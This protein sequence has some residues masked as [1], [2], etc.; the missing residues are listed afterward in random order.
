MVNGSKGCDPLILPTVKCK[1]MG[2]AGV[3]VESQGTRT[4]LLLAK[5]FGIDRE[6]PGFLRKRPHAL[7]QNPGD[8]HEKSTLSRI[9]KETEFTHFGKNI[10]CVNRY[11]ILV[12]SYDIVNPQLLLKQR[13][14]HGGQ[15]SFAT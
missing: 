12:C 10:K 7:L 13:T 6:N 11:P 4:T 3:R 8:A 5:N 15:C 1:S 2:V 14:I 9:K